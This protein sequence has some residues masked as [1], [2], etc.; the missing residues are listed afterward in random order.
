MLT[1][2]QRT[3]P[4]DVLVEIARDLTAS[5]ASTD[6][7]ERLLNAVERIV[8]CDAAC[9]LRLEDDEL[10]PVASRG[11]K[12]HVTLMR[13][14]RRVHPRFDV[15]LRSTNPVRFP[16]DSPL[17]D[18]YDG[19]L[20]AAPEGESR[21]HACLGCALLEQGRIVGALTADALDPEAFDLLDDGILAALGAGDLAILSFRQGAPPRWERAWI[22]QRATRYARERHIES[23]RW[24]A[25]SPH[26]ATSLEAILAML[27]AS[28][29][30]RALARWSDKLCQLVAEQQEASTQLGPIREEY[31]LAVAER[32]WFAAHAALARIRSLGQV[33]VQT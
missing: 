3:R 24:Y 11:L 31:R 1:H 19:L 14:D 22:E 18:P 6:R 2:S 10:V 16:P 28:P 15:I 7:Y 4:V 30:D 8:P 27:V 5:L 25:G 29:D 21:I 32:R 26:A 17:E 13:F 23:F 9:L 20:L 12:P 33:D